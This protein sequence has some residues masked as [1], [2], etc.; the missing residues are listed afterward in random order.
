MSYEWLYPPVVGDTITAGIR[1]PFS[2]VAVTEIGERLAYSVL[3]ER[4]RGRGLSPAAQV[5]VSTIGA[6]VFRVLLWTVVMAL[7]LQWIV[8]A[9]RQGEPGR[10]G[11][12]RSTVKS[13]GPMLVLGVIL[14]AIAA[15]GALGRSLVHKAFPTLDETVLDVWQLS[16]VHVI[17]FPLALTPFVIVGKRVGIVA[18]IA[19][20][21]WLIAA[22]SRQLLLIVVLYRAGFVVVEF[23]GRMA[24]FVSRICLLPPHL[25]QLHVPALESVRDTLMFGVS[26]A[27]FVGWMAQIAKYWT[28][29]G[30]DLLL[31]TTLMLLVLRTSATGTVRTS[32]VRVGPEN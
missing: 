12:W 14:I 13:L 28:S 5:E 30:L 22:L 24:Y 18:G 23:M 2:G 10:R 7:A 16:L 1:A 8:A 19:T 21:F 6:S 20:T 27:A 32:E 4:L 3:D 11:F 29:S 25:M 15:I 9:L 17:A 26:P 31:C